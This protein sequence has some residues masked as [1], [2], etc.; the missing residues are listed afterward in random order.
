VHA[1]FDA[2]TWKGI[3]QREPDTLHIRFEQ[4]KHAPP[5]PLNCARTVPVQFRASLKVPVMV[6]VSAQLPGIVHVSVK[7]PPVV[8]GEAPV[9]VHGKPL[10]TIVEPP[11]EN[12]V[13]G[14][15]IDT[16]PKAHVYEGAGVT[17]YVPL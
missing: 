7:L 17:V 10:A 4:S 14:R 6:Y 11:S 9:G 3:R 13:V 1:I 5:L 2:R 16:R 12:V 15:L 8:R